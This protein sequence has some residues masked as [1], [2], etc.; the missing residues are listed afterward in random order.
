MIVERENEEK[1]EQSDIEE[2]VEKEMK[3]IEYRIWKLWKFKLP[4]LNTRSN[5]TPWR[6]LIPTGKSVED[7]YDQEFDKELRKNAYFHLKHEKKDSKMRKPTWPPLLKR[8]RT[9]SL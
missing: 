9:T 4:S 3:F 6:D 7:Y 8:M 1:G 5:N 2:D